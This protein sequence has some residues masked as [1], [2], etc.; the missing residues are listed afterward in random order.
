MQT[1]AR[2]IILAK[3]SD[4]VKQNYLNKIY[5]RSGRADLNTDVLLL[6]YGLP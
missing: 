2:K 1:N 3:K 6:D 4:K 5:T